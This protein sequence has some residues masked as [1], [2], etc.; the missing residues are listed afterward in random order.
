MAGGG[1]GRTG[2]SAYLAFK[3]QDTRVLGLDAD[4]SI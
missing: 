1:M 4:L 3:Q 2:M